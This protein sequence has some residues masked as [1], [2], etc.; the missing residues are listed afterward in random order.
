[1]KQRTKESLA[2]AIAYHIQDILDSISSGYKF[3][4]ED[5]ERDILDMIEDFLSQ[6]K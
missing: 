6:E 4:L 2:N 1:M 5:E 3:N